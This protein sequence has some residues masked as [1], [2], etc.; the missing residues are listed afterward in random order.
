MR[1][2]YV[3]LYT[4]LILSLLRCRTFKHVSFPVC[5][6]FSFSS[7]FLSHEFSYLLLFWL[8][9]SLSCFSFYCYAYCAYNS[10]V[11]TCFLIFHFTRY[12]FRFSVSRL[13]D[14]VYTR[15]GLAVKSHSLVL[16]LQSTDSG[17]HKRQL[18]VVLGKV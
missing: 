1:L 14:L 8:C 10:F 5:S 9:F 12:G 2:Q 3:M 6:V 18:V 17:Y 11:V 13:F 4:I 15:I 16:I 7:N